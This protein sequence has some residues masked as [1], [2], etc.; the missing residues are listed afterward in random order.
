MKGKKRWIRHKK[1]ISL[2]ENLLSM[3]LF[4]CIVLG[5][6]EVFSLSRDHFIKIKASQE[7][8]TAAYS[9]LGKIKTDLQQCGK[10]F[11]ELLYPDVIKPLYA[12]DNILTGRSVETR[13]TL[14]NP[15]TAGQTRIELPSTTGFKKGKE[16]YFTDTTH[17]EIQ[18][19]SSIDSTSV[20]L[21]SSLIN[22][23]KVEESELN[24]LNKISF[25]FDKNKKVLRRKVNTSPAQPLC[26][27][28]HFFECNYSPATNLV[29][30][31]LSLKLNPEKVYEISVFPKNTALYAYR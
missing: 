17:G 28:V 31:R 14:N 26:E 11:T 25:Y 6:L 8:N 16:L 13:V 19:I 12:K 27:E 18:T 5:V 1:G 22:F 3:T 15:L 7:A 4:L 21:A 2:I 10:G 9:A 29:I 30:I 20:S 24:L 23:Y